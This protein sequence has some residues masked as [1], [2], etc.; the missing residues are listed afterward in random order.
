MAHTN[1]QIKNFSKKNN[2]GMVSILNCFEG[3][4]EAIIEKYE[5]E[6]YSNLLKS[7]KNQND[8]GKS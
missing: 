8:N 6:F 4:S 3:G 5:G 2:K 1:I 7:K